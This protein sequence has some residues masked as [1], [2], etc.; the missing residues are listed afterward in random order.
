MTGFVHLN[1]QFWRGNLKVRRNVEFVAI[2]GRLTPT[3]VIKNN[4]K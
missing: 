1:I 4:A 3:S 2:D